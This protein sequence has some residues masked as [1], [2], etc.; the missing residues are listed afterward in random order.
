M[1]V[2]VCVCAACLTAS[3]VSFVSAALLASQ[4]A[5]PWYTEELSTDLGN[6]FPAAGMM[7]INPFTA[8]ISLENYP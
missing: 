1:C 4:A 7:A 5:A 6:V 2:C 8:K 3:V